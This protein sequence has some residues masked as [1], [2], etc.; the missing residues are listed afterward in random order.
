VYNTIKYYIYQSLYASADYGPIIRRNNCVCAT[1]G[2]C[3]SVWM[4]VWYAPGCIPAGLFQWLPEEPSVLFLGKK[5]WY[6]QNGRL[7][8]PH[9]M[10]EGLKLISHAGTRSSK[11]PA[12]KFVAIPA[13]PSWL[14]RSRWQIKFATNLSVTNCVHHIFLAAVT[15][16]L[17]TAK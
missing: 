9:Y 6:P 10:S 13:A 2:T 8:G 1:L 7:C 15:L 4:T 14:I 17:L 12:R 11:L 3:Y 5:N 16:I